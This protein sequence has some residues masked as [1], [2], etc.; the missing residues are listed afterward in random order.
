MNYILF[1]LVGLFLIV[2]API[3]LIFTYGFV[4]KADKIENNY[5]IHK[6]GGSNF[7]HNYKF[8]VIT[9]NTELNEDGVQKIENEFFEFFVKN[10]NCKKVEIENNL[11]VKD[12][13]IQELIENKYY[14][15]F[16][17]ELPNCVFVN[18]YKIII[19][20]KPFKHECKVL[21]TEEVMEGRS[22]AYDF[23]DFDIDDNKVFC[24]EAD[25]FYNCVTCGTPCSVEG[26]YLEKIVENKTYNSDEI[27]T[28]IYNMFGE[29]GK[30]K[31]IMIDGKILNQL[32]EK[33]K[34][35]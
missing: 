29:Y 16:P 6:N 30:I 20:E 26:H 19:P 27:E 33:F 14:K 11:K 34:K 5:L 21:T 2:I 7:I 17:E 24:G 1:V 28:I 15:K 31:N 9:N 12:N 22:N 10:P 35:K 25:K 32:Y 18:K 8:I 4:V 3:S 13:G 23:I